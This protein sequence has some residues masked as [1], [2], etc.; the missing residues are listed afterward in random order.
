MTVIKLQRLTHLT[1]Q[2]NRLEHV[3][4]VVAGLSRLE[5][6]GLEGNPLKSPPPARPPGV[7]QFTNGPH[8]RFWLY[9]AIQWSRRQHRLLCKGSPCCRQLLSTV[10]AAAGRAAHRQPALPT[11]PAELWPVIF[12]ALL[13]GDLRFAQRGNAR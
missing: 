3:P 9:D 12:S 5:H 7:G 8:V 10:L 2:H 6:I 1:L 4:L 13:G 11:L